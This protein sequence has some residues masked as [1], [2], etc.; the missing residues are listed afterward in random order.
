[1]RKDDANTAAPDPEAE[2]AAL[3]KTWRRPEGWIGWF[4]ET[5]HKVLGIR[6]VATAFLFFV[7]AGALAALMRLQLAVPDN[8]LLTTDQYNQVFTTH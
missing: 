2:R 6:Y 4:M 7:M 1:M 8:T 5:D 3:E